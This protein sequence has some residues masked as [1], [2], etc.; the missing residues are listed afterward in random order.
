MAYTEHQD[1]KLGRQQNGYKG[2]IKSLFFELMPLHWQ[3]V[4]ITSLHA[5]F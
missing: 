2:I 5:P 3:L 1:T 4:F